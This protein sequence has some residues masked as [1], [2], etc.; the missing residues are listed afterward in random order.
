VADKQF[1]EAKLLYDLQTKSGINSLEELIPLLGLSNEPQELLKRVDRLK[2]GMPAEDEFMALAVWMGKCKLIHKFEQEQFPK[3]STEKYQVPDLLGV[4]DYEDTEIPVLIDVKVSEK[5]ALP[6][7]KFRLTASKYKKM[8]SY[9]NLLGLPLLIAWKISGYWTLF[10][11]REMQIHESAYYIDSSGAMKAD[12]MYLLLDSV[13]ITLMPRVSF[14]FIFED[15][16]I[17]AKKAENE[18]V[19]KMKTKAIRFTGYDGKPIAKMSM[20]Q[21]VLWLFAEHE[22]KQTRKGNLFEVAFEVPENASGLPAFA[23][24]P[25]ML[26]Q[27]NAE[28]KRPKTWYEVVKNETYGNIT[29]NQFKKAMKDGLGVFVQ[30]ILNIVP[31]KHPDFLPPMRSSED[32]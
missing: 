31:H 22:E 14:T 32:M 11:I 12:L 28:K 23:L 1:D 19:H 26:F 5:E 30:Y 27:M 24:L 7:A 25:L 9:A 13:H 15:L 16:G 21:F 8:T 17:T 3:V 4:F 6:Y 10:D 20:S 2:K 29:Y 18:E